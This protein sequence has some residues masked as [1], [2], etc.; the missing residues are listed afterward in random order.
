MIAFPEDDEV[1]KR[2]IAL[3]LHKEPTVVIVG[4]CKWGSFVPAL[5][6]LLYEAR[7]RN[8]Q[9]I[10]FQSVEVECPSQAI[11]DMHS[12][13]T[14]T[15]ALVVGLR[16]HGHAF[17]EGIRRLDGLTTPW[18]TMALWSVAKLCLIGFVMVA[19]GLEGEW[20]GG[21]EEVATIAVLQKIIGKDNAKAFVLQSGQETRQAEIKWNSEWLLLLCIL[22]S[23][24]Y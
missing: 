6:R 7:A 5:N 2:E 18:N 17:Q 24:V 4:V 8:A 23:F 22:V 10:L 13:L 16:L 19:E 15:N 9:H 14:S 11:Q 12:T 3:Q 20:L 21:V 1:L